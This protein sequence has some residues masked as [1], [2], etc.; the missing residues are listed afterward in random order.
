[1][2]CDEGRECVVGVLDTIRQDSYL[3]KYMKYNK[4]IYRVK[5]RVK[6]FSLHRALE[7]VE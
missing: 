5:A 3:K 4:N 2:T 6:F 1:M 7:V